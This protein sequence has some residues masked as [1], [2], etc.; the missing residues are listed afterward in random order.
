M[1][2]HA[3]RR[4][5]HAARRTPHQ[6]RDHGGPSAATRSGHAGGGGPRRLFRRDAALAGAGSS[7]MSLSRARSP[8]AIRTS[9]GRTPNAPARA[10]RTASFAFPSTAGAATATSNAAP[11]APSHRPPTAALRA[12]GLTRTAN[13]KGCVLTAPRISH[14]GRRR[15]VALAWRRLDAAPAWRGAGLAPWRGVGLARRRRGDTSEQDFGTHNLGRW[16]E[17]PW[18]AARR[19]LSNHEPE[20]REFCVP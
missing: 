15:L 18:P 17:P 4:T 20:L 2:P 8:D 1:A 10:R 16:A 13:R 6:D 11:D 14:L 12:P 5:P 3:A 7:S 9:R 19:P